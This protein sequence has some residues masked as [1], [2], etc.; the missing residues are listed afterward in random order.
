MPKEQEESIL[1]VEM[2]YIRRDLDE[3]KI[4]L[5]GSY[6]TKEEFQPVK[7]IVYGLVALILVAVV[8]ALVA[9]VVNS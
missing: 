6:V 4:K 7:N 5:D 9:L 2:R 8:G 3:I 1:V